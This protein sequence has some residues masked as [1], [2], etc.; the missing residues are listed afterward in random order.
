M[1]SDSLN[2][3]SHRRPGRETVVDEND[4]SAPKIHERR[5][6]AVLPLAPFELL[7]LLPH[8][9][10]NRSLRNVVRPH[11]VFAEH[12]HATRRP[13]RRSRIPGVPACRVFA[14]GRCRVAHRVTRQLQTPPVRRR[15]ATPGPRRPCARRTVEVS[16]P[17]R[18]QLHAGLENKGPMLRRRK[19][20]ATRDCTLEPAAPMYVIE[21]RVLV[22]GGEGGIRTRSQPLIATSSLTSWL[23]TDVVMPASDWAHAAAS[24]AVPNA[25]SNRDVILALH[26]V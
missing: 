8:H 13:S 7:L 17:A 15:A 24:T 1:L 19:V 14:R 6:A 26:A 22:N 16:T 21:K 23:F 4:E 9:D 25:S 2:R 5:A 3:R 11:H 20:G 18:D 12:T 10:V